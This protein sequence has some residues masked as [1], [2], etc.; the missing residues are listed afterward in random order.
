MLAF[1]RCERSFGII[2]WFDVVVIQIWI[3]YFIS[4]RIIS[5]LIHIANPC[6][7]LAIWSLLKLRSPRHRRDR[8]ETQPNSPT[9]TTTTTTVYVSAAFKKPK[10]P[11]YTTT[12]S[13]SW[14]TA[15][16]MCWAGNHR[17]SANFMII[18]CCCHRRM[19]VSHSHRFGF[20]LLLLRFSRI[21]CAHTSACVCVCERAHFFLHF[22]FGFT[23]SV[24]DMILNNKMRWTTKKKK[25][26]FSVHSQFDCCCVFDIYR[27]DV[28]VA[29]SV[30][31]CVEWRSCWM[32]TLN[33]NN[34]S[35]L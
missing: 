35:S 34:S 9:T 30:S 10:K 18:A 31:V 12:S 1:T 14:A 2:W 20:F 22:H 11:R 13:S 24:F 26:F 28:T 19:S 7:W 25:V 27:R 29:V 17:K 33:N 3:V 4:F 21:P 23:I 8:E 16:T 15:I 5:M 32:C 6:V